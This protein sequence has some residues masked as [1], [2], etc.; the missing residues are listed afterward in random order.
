MKSLAQLFLL[1]LFVPALTFAQSQVT[2]TEIISR[3]NRGEALNYKNARI[4]GD[5]DLTQLANK[6]LQSN[7]KDNSYSKIYV[8][9]V[10]APISFSN[11]TFSGK[12]IGYYNPDANKIIFNNNTGNTIYNTDFEKDVQFVKC[13]FEDHVNFTYSAFRGAVSFAESQFQKIAFF[14]YSQFT[15]GPDF[16]QATFKDETVFKYVKF[17]GKTSFAQ[18]GFQGDADFKY[19]QFNYGVNFARTTFTRFANFKSAQLD[20]PVNLQ[21]MVFTGSQDFKYTQV[22][23]RSANLAQRPD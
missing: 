4:E 5:L 21:G 14:K 12:V 8:S 20:G 17:P 6:K 19:A 7:Q 16:S 18:A 13:T 22:N 15:Q 10:T 3:I 11:C 23:G 9:T 2:A 1:F